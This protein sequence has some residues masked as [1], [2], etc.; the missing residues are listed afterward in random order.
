MEGKSAGSA[1]DISPGY[2]R[3]RK[4]CWEC[5]GQ[6]AQTLIYI[7]LL[8]SCHIS[9]S[10]KYS[11]AVLSLNCNKFTL[12]RSFLLELAWEEGKSV[13]CVELQ[14]YRLDS[15]IYWIGR[16]VLNFDGTEEIIS[17]S[18]CVWKKSSKGKNFHL[19]F[20]FFVSEKYFLF[21]AWPSK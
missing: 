2:F 10:R 1:V 4:E 19:F 16:G 9:Y 17:C 6:V 7:Q 15:I 3:G 13:G 8:P 14:T 18:I 11:A 5:Y 20:R 21:V 12:Y